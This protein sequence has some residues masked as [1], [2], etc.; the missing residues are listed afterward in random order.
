MIR[1]K[2][3]KYEIE[4]ILEAFEKAGVDLHLIWAGSDLEKMHTRLYYLSK[5]IGFRRRLTKKIETVETQ[6]IQG[7]SS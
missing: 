5:G 6:I 3:S 7:E 1:P 4:L 2:F